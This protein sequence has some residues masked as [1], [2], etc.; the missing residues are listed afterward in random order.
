[1][2]PIDD[3]MITLTVSV[4]KSVCRSSDSRC[5]SGTP[6]LTLMEQ[7]EE[8]ES[9]VWASLMMSPKVKPKHLHR[10][11]VTG[12]RINRITPTQ[13]SRCEKTK[14]LNTSKSVSQICFLGGSYQGDL[15]SRYDISTLW[16]TIRHFQI[17]KSAAIRFQ[18]S[19]PINAISYIFTF[20]TN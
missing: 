20:Y 3:T 10:P 11:L 17:S 8:A 7:E 15:C 5:V 12:C 19:Y 18:F 1:M 13:V 2:T 14:N 4:T 6:A 16:T 9:F